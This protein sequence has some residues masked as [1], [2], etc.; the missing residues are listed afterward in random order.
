MLQDRDFCNTSV[1]FVNALERAGWAN[2][3]T[4]GQTGSDNLSKT[5]LVPP[6]TSRGRELRRGPSS[7]GIPRS[8][9]PRPLRFTKGGTR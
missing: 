8:L 3:F 7:S 2:Q 4:V 6:W 5:P 1:P 9:R